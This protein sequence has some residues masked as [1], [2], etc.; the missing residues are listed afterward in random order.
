MSPDES[1]PPSLSTVPLV[2][3]AV[4]AAL[5][6]VG[7]ISDENPLV[8]PQ[9][10]PLGEVGCDREAAFVIDRG[11]GHRRAVDFRLEEAGHHGNKT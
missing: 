5:L 2:G 11:A 1:S 9:A 6:A 8:G 3:V 4:N 10:D 7:E